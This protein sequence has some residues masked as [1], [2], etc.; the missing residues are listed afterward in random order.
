[1]VDA[2]IDDGDLVVVS[3]E[4]EA[5]TGDIV[6][7]MDENNESSITVLIRLPMKQCCCIAIRRYTPV[8]KSVLK[9]Y[10]FRALP[11]T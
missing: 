2:G 6:V 4:T 11:S 10:L 1:M 8:R 5:E 9:N 3:K 7:A